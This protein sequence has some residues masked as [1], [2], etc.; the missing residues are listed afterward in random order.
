MTDK[1]SDLGYTP[2]DRILG[3]GEEYLIIKREGNNV[4]LTESFMDTTKR[5]Y[6]DVE[7]REVPIPNLST[8]KEISDYA[9]LLSVVWHLKK[10]GIKQVPLEDIMSLCNL[11]GALDKAFRRMGGNA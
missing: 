5:V 6:D 2:T 10:Y 11:V 7:A 3:L 4:L 9:C 8:D 1:L